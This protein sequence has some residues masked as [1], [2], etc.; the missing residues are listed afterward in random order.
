MHTCGGL[1]GGDDYARR[2]RREGLGR[3]R[4]LSY[5]L[6]RHLQSID[7]VAAW[8]LSVGADASNYL[9]HERTDESTNPITCASHDAIAGLSIP[10]CIHRHPRRRR[11][12]NAKRARAI[13]AAT[14]AAI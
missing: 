8:Y 9:S 12:D 13:A 4:V 5:G 10:A 6:V 14:T 7:V 2:A 11:N 3:V 1:R